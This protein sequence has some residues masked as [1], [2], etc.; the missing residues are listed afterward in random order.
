M[1]N[2]SMAKWTVIHKIKLMCNCK[3]PKVFNRL[4]KYLQERD[5]ICRISKTLLNMELFC[6]F[7]KYLLE[8]ALLREHFG[9]SWTRDT[10]TD[11]KIYT[12]CLNKFEDGRKL[13]SS[14]DYSG[15]GNF[16]LSDQNSN[17]MSNFNLAG[18][19]I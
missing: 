8:L 17:I 14:I 10:K 2:G 1:Q 9:T 11:L 12:N 4:N 5:T 13:T 18:N 15:R 19:L 16:T 3:I 6:L 7:S